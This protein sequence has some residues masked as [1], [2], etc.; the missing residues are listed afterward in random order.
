MPWTVYI[1]RSLSLGGYYKG[2]C[3]D[4]ERRLHNHN[5]GRVKSTKAGRPWTIHYSEILLNK[6]EALRRERFFKSRSGYR[7]LKDHN[8]I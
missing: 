7:W 3:E 2:S 6:T 8:I 4:I 5:A 1:I